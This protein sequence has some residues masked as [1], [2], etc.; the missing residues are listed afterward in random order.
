MQETL[1]KIVERLD[2]QDARHFEEQRRLEAQKFRQR[3]ESFE[4]LE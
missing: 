4:G 3:T 1:N 2:R